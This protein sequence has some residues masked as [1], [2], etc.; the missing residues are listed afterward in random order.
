[1]NV[2][3]AKHTENGSNVIIYNKFLTL[4]LKLFLIWKKVI[5][6][7][8]QLRTVITR[9]LTWY[10]EKKKSKS[11]RSFTLSALLPLKKGTE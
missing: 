4:D 7:Q 5:E 11:R 3:K 1:M 2:I 8:W 6:M 10:G 9:S